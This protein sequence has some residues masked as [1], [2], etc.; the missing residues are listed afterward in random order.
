MV[1]NSKITS[2]I[3]SLDEEFSMILIATVIIPSMFFF[4]VLIFFILPMEF[5]TDYFPEAAGE[6]GAIKFHVL[7]QLFNLIISV[8]FSIMSIFRKGGEGIAFV[9]IS[10]MLLASNFNI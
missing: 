5:P 8:F 2:N 1:N 9:S 6:N 10:Y 4:F 7:F 3:E